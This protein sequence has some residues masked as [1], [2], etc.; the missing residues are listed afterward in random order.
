MKNIYNTITSNLISS[1]TNKIFKTLFCS[2]IL[3]IS[4]VS[5]G[6]NETVISYP[7]WAENS[8]VY[9]MNIRQQSQE[10]NFAA[11]KERLPF[12][13]E[14]GVDIVWLMPIHP[15]GQKG[16][17]G[18]LGSYYAIQNYREI[19]PEFGTMEDFESF[20]TEAHRLGLKV[21]L[22]LV[23]NHTSPDSD[24]I[25]DKPA[26]WYHR[27]STGAPLV[28]YDW[29]DISKLNYDCPEVRTEMENVMQ[30]WVDKG[31]DGFRCDVAGEVPD[32]FWKKA[33]AKVRKTNPDL[34]LLAEGEGE[35]FNEAGFNATYSWELLHLLED[36]VADAEGGDFK[37]LNDKNAKKS[38]AA[39]DKRLVSKHKKGAKDLRALMEKYEADYPENAFKLMFTSNHD[40]NSWA[41]SEFERYGDAAKTM[42]AL[43]YTLPM[44]QPLIYTG[45]EIGFD[46][47]FKFFDKDAIQDWTE[48]EYTAFYRSLN[49]FK[50]T[51]PVLST[52]GKASRAEFMSI[53]DSKIL[54]FTREND[55]ERIYCIFNLTS[56][57]I[58]I[59]QNVIMDDIDDISSKY[60]NNDETMG[61][62]DVLSRRAEE[63]GNLIQL[64]PWGY[65]IATFNK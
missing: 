14:L 29:T 28:Q 17:K 38:V 10:G 23:A 36:I 7:E 19:N 44:G 57:N 8:V 18:T 16:R 62:P 39:D 53:S 64:G 13:S 15:I 52:V 34:Y 22:D 11:A 45:Q 12:L 21:I 3:Y 48:N 20:L 42:A 6:N 43:T 49:N 55:F 54:A 59:N 40:E 58:S 32:S 46:H 50:H 37:E 61:F 63:N 60:D 35:H 30:F 1:S 31:V 47:R 25:D 4:C 26:E 33:I 24:W 51:H 2:V 27:D 65:L 9:E 56:E 5:C 41:G